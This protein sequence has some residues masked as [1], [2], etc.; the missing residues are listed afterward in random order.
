MQYLHTFVQQ[1]DEM[2]FF[3]NFHDLIVGI[4]PVFPFK[5]LHVLRALTWKE[6]Q[7]IIS[8]EGFTHSVNLRFPEESEERHSKIGKQIPANRSGIPME[9]ELLH[10]RVRMAQEHLLRPGGEKGLHSGW[11]I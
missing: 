6:T 8:Q 11:G 9:I 4:L 2:F 7:P 5:D 10:N 3:Q 1:I